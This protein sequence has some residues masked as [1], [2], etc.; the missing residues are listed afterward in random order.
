MAVHLEE[1]RDAPLLQIRQVSKKYGDVEV[2]RDIDF[3]LRASTVHGVIGQNGAGKSTLVGIVSGIV[4]PDSGE[5]L[6]SGVP[7][8]K[9]SPKASLSVGIATVYQE[10]SLLS[11]LSVYENM[12]LG[13][14]IVRDHRLCKNEMIEKTSS[15]LLELGG[16]EID[17]TSKTWRLSLA[18]RQL[19]EIA[20]CV[21]RNVEVLILDEPSAVL[22]AHELSTLF[23]LI[24]RLNAR[25]TGVIYISHRLSEVE[26]ISDQITVLRDGKVSL[27]QDKS[28]FVRQEL[29]RAMIGEELNSQSSQGLSSSNES[30]FSVDELKLHEDD[31]EGIS[32]KLATGEILGVIGHTGSGRSRLLK[33]LVGLER[34]RGGSVSLS[35]SRYVGRKLK[36]LN[37]SGVR[38]LPE[39]RKKLGL[40]LNRSITDNI[41]V[42]DLLQFS[43][44]GFL[45]HK[46]IA[47]AVIKFYTKL[48]IRAQGIEQIV[49][50]LSGGNQQKVLLARTMISDPRI[51]L[52][53][54][55]LRGVDVGA[56]AEIIAAIKDHVARG[57]AAIVVSSELADIVALAHRVLVM[58]DGLAH[59]VIDK[60]DIDENYLAITVENS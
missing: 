43:V 4:V 42:S 10:L 35:G 24:R 21:R 13:D 8:E 38:Y 51:L 41:I 11:E 16:Q 45:N 40:F 27:L 58:R 1:R 7:I 46:R 55:P 34:V 14:E 3:S 30:C 22:G 15:L 20:R 17:P 60:S 32:F 50:R 31:K 18:Q 6:L 23:E 48:G 47:N 56:K 5:V 26:H 53:D 19:V 54:E 44:F 2:L 28:N 29:I 52:L 9:G 37:R 39:D 57:N 12:F 36:K 25:G 33:S 59:Q 49:A